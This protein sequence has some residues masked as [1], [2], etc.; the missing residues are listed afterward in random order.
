MARQGSKETTPDLF[1]EFGIAQDAEDVA[2]TSDKMA[3]A[4]LEAFGMDGGEPEPDDPNFWEK[5]DKKHHH[6]NFD[7]ETQR[8]SLRE[9]AE[10]AEKA[11]DKDDDIG[12]GQPN[13]A[14]LESPEKRGAEERG[15]DLDWEKIDAEYMDA[16]ERGDMEKCAEMVRRAAARAIPDTKVVDKDG[17]PLVVYHGGKNNSF[18]VFEHG[19]SLENGAGAVNEYTDVE[20]VGFY[21][22]PNK[23]YAAQYAG[24]KNPRAFFV[25]IK[26][27]YV[28]NGNSDWD[29]RIDN[30]KSRKFL[31][32][33]MVRYPTQIK[34]ADPV[35][36]DDNGNVIPLSKRFQEGN[37]DIRF[38]KEEGEA[39]SAWD[40][41]TRAEAEAA[42]EVLEKCL[43]GTT[44]DFAEHEYQGDG[45][46]ESRASV[47]PPELDA[48]YMDAVER[49]DLEKCAEIVQEA[50]AKAGY[51][52][53]AWHYGDLALKNSSDY[54]IP[55]GETHYGTREAALDRLR[56][57]ADSGA[58]EW[59]GYK[60]F[61]KDGKWFWQF[62]SE[63]Y[64]TEEEAIKDMTSGGPFAT[65]EQAEDDMA[66]DYGGKLTKVYLNVEGARTVDEDDPKLQKGEDI[67]RYRNAQEDPGSYSFKVA[68]PT[69]VKSAAPV[70]YDDDGN[71]IPLSKRFDNVSDDIR[72]AKTGSGYS[73]GAP[74]QGSKGRIASQIID[75]LPEGSRFVDLFSG[76][77]AMTHAAMLS[78]KFDSYRMNDISPKG[79]DL[80]L[81]GIR[82]E[83]NDYKRDGMTKES[84][85]GIKGTPEGIIWSFN[86]KG[87]EF[88]GGEEGLK[89]A[90]R[91]IERMKRLGELSGKAD[92]VNASNLDYRQVE[93]RPGDVLYA[94]IP[95]E[96]MNRRG[97]GSGSFD[98]EAFIKWAEGLEQPVFV[99]EHQMPDGWTEIGSW[100]VSGI[101]GRNPEEKLFV[102]DRFA[103]RFPNGREQRY[104]RNG[105]GKVV[106]TYDRASGKITLYP[107][108]KAK[109][110]VHEFSHGLWQFAEQEAAAGRSTLMTKFRAIADSAPQA[111]KDA[112]KANYGTD[113]PNV[114]LEE[115][116]T[117]EMARQSEGDSAFAKAIE[118]PEGRPWY[119]RAWGVIK[120]TWNRFA[121]AKKLPNVDVSKMEGMDAAQSAKF[122]LRQLAK[123]AHF[124]TVQHTGNGTRK[125]IIGVKGAERLG[126][127]K[128]DEAQKIS[129]GGASREDIWR[130]TGWWRGKDGK[131]RVEVPDVILPFETL[132]SVAESK[133]AHRFLMQNLDK[134]DVSTIR[135]L[136]ERAPEA[137]SQYAGMKR[138]VEDIER[139]E[140]SDQFTVRDFVQDTGLDMAYPELMK[141]PVRFKL[142]GSDIGLR[143]HTGGYFDGKQIVIDR[144]SE[145]KQI[146]SHIAHELQHAIQSIEGFARG[147]NGNIVD[148]SQYVRSAGEVESRNIQKRLDMTPEMHAAHP[149]WE[150]EDVPE[151]MQIVV[152][153]PR[154]S[155][156]PDL[157][158][159]FGVT[160][161]EAIDTTPDLFAEFGVAKDEAIGDSAPDLF[162]ENG[163]NDGIN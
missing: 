140:A 127:G 100:N 139:R 54:N 73:L 18:T 46:E 44:V 71:V 43:Y 137:Y 96:G 157:F 117:H 55:S 142:Q 151:D 38:S 72:Y 23:E 76:G 16:V 52:Q 70:T 80:F 81:Q 39:G 108:A 63:F 123:G 126:M 95:Y 91:N 120:S 146:R 42:K 58:H 103:N 7:P 97:Y 154:Q 56:N 99:S 53:E 110:V 78:G 115:C 160:G 37:P 152:N 45:G 83:W 62:K 19:H 12:S 113:N 107:G 51:T 114:Y 35:T 92:K 33:V 89:H 132:P 34:S 36:Y 30:W 11:K 106:G 41:T 74:Y 47:V 125:S 66:K 25:D 130:K 135:Q 84:F 138:K 69:R 148:R 116:F 101:R 133:K 111:V 129:K 98:K 60:M 22:S 141:M 118:T 90:R 155:D 5:H 136:E 4:F 147:A 6:G 121:S 102:Q 82:G 134:Y 15:G 21:F 48:E 28:K 131:W 40:A 17:L 109:D 9:E 143:E 67:V 29:G 20:D 145:P 27:P 59:A 162:K 159:E 104:F 26:R 163:I 1:E 32:E 144:L 88:A 10:Q 128:L 85:E 49:G 150:T 156:T 57:R 77:G 61:E 68:D 161:D 119:R 64:D 86:N 31:T 124:G 112:V 93:I 79:Q 94:D 65:K 8:C 3:E 50:A 149:P 24:G 75:L 2:I 13:V 122:I 105:E 14:G 158:A 87:N 153:E